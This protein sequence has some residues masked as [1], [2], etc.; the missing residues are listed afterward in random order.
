[1]TELERTLVELGRARDHPPVP[2]LADA[3]AARLH[4]RPSHCNPRVRRRGAIVLMLVLVLPAG[5]VAA[6]PPVREAVLDAFGIGAVRIERTTTTPRAPA[7]RPLDLGRPVKPVAA[8]A[9]VDFDVVVADV[10]L[11]SPTEAYVRS[12]PAGPALT[13]VYAPTAGSRLL[14]TEFRGA[15]AADLVGKLVGRSTTV[16]RVR[17]NGERGVWLTGRPHEVAFLDAR[18]R[19]RTDRLSLAGDTLLWQRGPL[20]LRLEG[21][22]SKAAALRVARSV[23]SFR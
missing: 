13:F 21:A 5:A 22:A 14:L 8:A 3:V 18:G 1:M 7:G 12:A 17:V 15:R 16:E 19:L 2:D 4:A 9:V 10:R 20:T 6:V 23:R 11:G